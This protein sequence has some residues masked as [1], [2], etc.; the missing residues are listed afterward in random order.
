MDNLW[1]IS[2][3]EKDFHLTTYTGILTGRIVGATAGVVLTFTLTLIDPA[4][5]LYFSWS[6]IEIVVISMLVWLA[7]CA[8]NTYG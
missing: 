7:L 2:D 5:G 3:S 4:G 1:S 6:F 8:G